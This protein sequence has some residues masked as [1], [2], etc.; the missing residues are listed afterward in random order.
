MKSCLIH[1]RIHKNIL[2]I[3]VKYRLCNGSLMTKY[4]IPTILMAT[5][6]VV[7]IFAFVPVDN[8][9]AV[10]TTLQ[11]TNMS[12]QSDNVD[13]SGETVAA[14][15]EIQI[16]SA[17]AF[18]MTSMYVEFAALEDNDIL[19]TD[20]L[21]INDEELSLTA[22]G[23]AFAQ[24][25]FAVDINAGQAAHIKEVLSVDADVATILDVICA[26]AGPRLFGVAIILVAVV[27]LNFYGR[28]LVTRVLAFWSLLLYTVFIIYLATVFVTMS[29]A[30]TL[31][32]EHNGVG[33]GW[34][35]SGMQYS[36]YNVTGIP[37]ILY[38]A[39][40]IET[41]RQALTS[42]LVGA[43]IALIPALML[44]LSF[45]AVYPS[46]LEAE[47][48][49]YEV[50]SGLG[51]ALLKLAYLIVLFGTFIETGAGSIQGFIERLD[52]WWAERHEQPL[53][54]L[55]HG[56]IA[57]VAVLLAGSLSAFGIVALIADGY[58]TLAWGFL[59]VYVGPLLTIGVYKIFFAEKSRKLVKNTS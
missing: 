5:A 38:A 10:H 21:E 58:G 47:L 46:I 18:C 43:L 22:A 34:F 54:R 24:I 25:D 20:D 59:A 36:F 44:H 14:D 53:K 49:V 32:L 57:G 31:G 29:D 15:E 56:W 2:S 1:C 42:G 23:A 17:G 13:L 3:S 9:T 40:A 52:G 7:G 8:A 37:I 55:T 50:F 12:L 26:P 35:V 11:G 16:T 4:T 6:L 39:M 51:F 19:N 45:I 27:V 30:F 41:R 48:P 33:E 28:E